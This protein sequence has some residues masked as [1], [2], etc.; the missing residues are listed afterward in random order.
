MYKRTYKQHT[1]ATWLRDAAAGDLLNRLTLTAVQALDLFDTQLEASVKTEEQH[2]C[3]Q[4]HLL[5]EH[6][7]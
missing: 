4:F 2:W 1:G 7:K 5:F 3:A 6:K